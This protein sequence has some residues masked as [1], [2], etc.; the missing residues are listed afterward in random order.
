LN[1]DNLGMMMM[2][3]DDNDNDH[4]ATLGNIVGHV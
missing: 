4:D 3:D 1:N 2:H